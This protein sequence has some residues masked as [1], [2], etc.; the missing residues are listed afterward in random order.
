[1]YNFL[2]SDEP[3]LDF[4]EHGLEAQPLLHEPTAD[5][6]VPEGLDVGPRIPETSPNVLG[7][8]EL[9]VGAARVLLFAAH[10]AVPEVPVWLCGVIL[11]VEHDSHS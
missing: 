6:V 9:L 4:P 8:V 1:M 2:R 3:D 11:A 7:G 10:P 5:P